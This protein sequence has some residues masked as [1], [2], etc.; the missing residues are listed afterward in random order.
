[1]CILC[2]PQPIWPSIC[3]PIYQSSVGRHIDW[4][5]T[6][7]SVDML[8][9]TRP[10]YQSRC[11]GRHV[12]RDFN[13]DISR[14]LD[15]QLLCNN[16]LTCRLIGYRHSANT[17]LLLAYWWLTKKGWNAYNLYTWHWQSK[18]STYITRQSTDRPPTG[19]Q[20]STD[21]QHSTYWSSVG[22]YI[23]RDIYR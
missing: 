16:R 22:P 5:S 11:L 14:Y 8:T 20:Y 10:I 1:M 6:D 12:D 21:N 18:L 13:Q 23:N 3:W 17:S 4:C 19:D 2:T 15:R 7:V 9:D